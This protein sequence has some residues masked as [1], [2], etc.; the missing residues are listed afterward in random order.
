MLCL[1][2][3]GIGQPLAMHLFMLAPWLAPGD[4]D[5]ARMLV[6]LLTLF[7]PVVVLGM[8]SIPEP[9]AHPRLRDVLRTSAWFPGLV[10]M[11]IPIWSWR[12]GLGLEHNAPYRI[13]Y[14]ALQL[15]V[16]AVWWCSL[17]EP[18]I[19]R[20]SYWA[21]LIGLSCAVL[22]VALC[23]ATNFVLEWSTLGGVVEPYDP[24][25][26]TASE[27]VIAGLGSATLTLVLGSLLAVPLAMLLE[28]LQTPRARRLKARLRKLRR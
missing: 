21:R 12:V 17:R 11:M 24:F 9:H 23:V 2:L 14:L 7:G 8:L 27:A 15:L 4:P 18:R 5:W 3:A 25:T 16:V 19:P 10:L 26:E 13:A 20:L 1:L 22:G 6:R 28:K